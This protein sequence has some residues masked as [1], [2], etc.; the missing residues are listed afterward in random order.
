MQF[1]G[2]ESGVS[3]FKPIRIFRG[4]DFSRNNGLANQGLKP[5]RTNGIITKYSV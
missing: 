5:W 3:G 4:F 2:L 1:D